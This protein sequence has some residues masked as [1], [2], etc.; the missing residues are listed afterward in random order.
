MKTGTERQQPFGTRFDGVG[1]RSAALA[2]A[3][4]R[5]LPV[6]GANRISGG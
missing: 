4:R 2:V 6:G 5:K 1:R 3:E